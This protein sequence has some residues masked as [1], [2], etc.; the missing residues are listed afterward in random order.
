MEYLVNGKVIVD[1]LDELKYIIENKTISLD[2]IDIKE[3]GLDSLEEAF[4]NIKEIKG[5]IDNWDVSNIR[6]LNCTFWKAKF[7]CDLSKWDVSNVEDMIKTFA[8]SN[9]N[10]DSLKNWNLSKVDN[11]TGMFYSSKF[12]GNISNWDVSN[13]HLM[14]FMFDSCPFNGDISKWQFKPNFNC[15]EI[16]SNNQNFY[17][18][19]NNGKKISDYTIDFL[20]W[21][22]NNRFKIRD[23]NT[24]ENEVLD[25][26]SFEN[27]LNIVKE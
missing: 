27:N 8:Y 23:K 22:E 24:S 4:N 9:F 11:C 5:S 10:N 19:Y 3:S 6:S 17:D 26:F 14:K 25:F 20:T 1:D 2:L 18:K 13:I 16:F 12:N 21:F 7:Q 15:H